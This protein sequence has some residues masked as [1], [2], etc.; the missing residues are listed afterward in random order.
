M[1]LKEGRFGIHCPIGLFLPEQ[2]PLPGALSK[3]LCGAGSS[4]DFK[5]LME[6]WHLQQQFPVPCQAHPQSIHLRHHSSYFLLSATGYLNNR[7]SLFLCWGICLSCIVCVCFRSP[8]L[9]FKHLQAG[10]EGVAICLSPL[11]PQGL[12]H[13][14]CSISAR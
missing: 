9:D 4:S 8:N 11:C 13:S 2:T 10:V 14:R 3:A 1:N 12:S 7:Y 5:T 6:C